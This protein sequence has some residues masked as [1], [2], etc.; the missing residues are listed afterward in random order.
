MLD[1]ARRQPPGR[2]PIHHYSLATGTWFA[3]HG[4]QSVLFAWLVTMALRESPQLV[5]VAQMAML[6]PAML[7]MLFAGSVA[8]ALGGRRVA[9]LAQGFAVLPSLG[10]LAA[11]LLDALSYPLM[12]L[13]AV[14]M[15][16]AIAFV[17]PARDGL[18][19]QVAE[20]RIQ[21]TVVLVSLAQFGV[22]T[23]GF[24]VA[25]LAGAIGPAPVIAFQAAVLAVGV[26]AYRRLPAQPPL[27][28][29]GGG[30]GELARA[31]AEGCGTVLRSAAMRGVVVQN[32][33]MG[34]F[35]MGSYI[36]SVPLLI[37]EVYAGSSVDLA[38]VNA[39]NMVGLVTSILWLLAAGDVRRQGRALLLAHAL[40]CVFLAATGAVAYGS[41][42]GLWALAGC[43]YLWGACGGVA[44][45]M[46]RTI[47][48]EA[49]PEGQRGRVMAFFSFS[50]MGAGP[51]GALLCGQLVGAVGAPLALMVA[52][53]AV[54]VVIVAVGLRSHLWRM[55]TP[56]HAEAAAARHG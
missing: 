20:G 18:L 53:A 50:F 24:L 40:G 7:L 27:R 51:I 48:Q 29:A 55:R 35:F 25:G 3:A 41:P 44:M 45:S 11:L 21:R 31:V 5:G 38:I 26:A 14:L 16:C 33:A 36:V 49:A 8:D 52:S 17:T 13:Y 6:M 4:V 37:R 2:R 10:L 39:A 15:G 12:L 47:M 28:G 32:I 9:M 23:V 56:V 46:S 1:V 42:F 54:M 22:Q 43:I 34:L 19:N 30:L